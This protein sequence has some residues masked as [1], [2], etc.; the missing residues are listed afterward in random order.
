MVRLLAEPSD[1]KSNIKLDGFRSRLQASDV[2][3]PTEEFW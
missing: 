2:S 1:T 3:S